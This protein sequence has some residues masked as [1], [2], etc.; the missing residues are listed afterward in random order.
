MRQQRQHPIVAVILTGLILII[1][2]G[3]LAV[4]VPVP[5]PV[6]G[7]PAP[8]PVYRGYYRGGH[9]HHHHRHPGHGYYR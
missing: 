1:A 4:P 5:G 7:P 8:R 3:C 9:H 2:A 6:F